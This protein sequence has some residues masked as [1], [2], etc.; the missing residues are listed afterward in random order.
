MSNLN[1][2]D[3]NGVI[4]GVDS[5]E[6]IHT[7]G[8]L[9]KTVHV[10]FFT[11]KGE[12]IFQHRSKN[13]DNFPDLL[14]ATVGGHVEIGQDYEDT[15]LKEIIEEAGIKV[16]K[17]ELIFIQLQYDKNSDPVTGKTENSLRTVYAY[18]FSGNLTDLKL[19]PGQGLGFEA[20]S[21]ERIFNISE[22]DSKKFI[23]AILKEPYLGIFRK[24]QIINLN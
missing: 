11:P 14:D 15:A 3:E 8:L 7:K 19:E 22:E 21:F 16:K 13:V 9:H 2:V 5:R 24:L 20:W 23:P 4:I 18:C 10:W 17:E 6:N 12:I 1:I